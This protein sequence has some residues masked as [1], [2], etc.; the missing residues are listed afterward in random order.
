MDEGKVLAPV[1]P[2]LVQTDPKRT[3]ETME[4][5]LPPKYKLPKSS[6]GNGYQR[7]RPENCYAKDVS[8]RLQQEH[9]KKV[10]NAPSISLSFPVCPPYFPICPML[11][12]VI[13][14]EKRYSLPDIPKT[15]LP[16][17][18]SIIKIL[19]VFESVINLKP[20]LSTV[21]R[22]AHT[23]NL[24]SERLDLIRKDLSALPQALEK[25]FPE[26]SKECKELVAAVKVAELQYVMDGQS[27]V[28]LLPNDLEYGNWATFLRWREQQINLANVSEQSLPVR[29]E[30]CRITRH[31]PAEA[32]KAMREIHSK[33]FP[34]LK[35]L[36]DRAREYN[37]LQNEI[38][39]IVAENL[40]GQI[41]TKPLN[42]EEQKKPTMVEYLSGLLNLLEELQ[43]A[44]KNKNEKI[45]RIIHSH[46]GR[47]EK[48]IGSME[49]LAD[50]LRW[51]QSKYGC[52]NE[53]THS[54]LDW[55]SA[56]IP[57]KG[58]YPYPALWDA[59]ADPRFINELKRWIKSA[60]SR[61]EETKPIELNSKRPVTLDTFMMEYCDSKNCDIPSKRLAIYKAAKQKRITLPKLAKKW[62]T[63]KTKVFYDTDLEA[64]WFNYCKEITTLPTL[65]S[66]KAYPSVEKRRKA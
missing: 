57:S 45:I 51:C 10:Y 5:R 49:H 13:K 24:L 22:C 1:L 63:G 34:L 23:E 42:G 60:S 37:H 66:K 32:I 50:V 20:D 47:I 59:L 6:N 58:L 16:L 53:Y 39:K 25:D 40:V 28:Y 65:K 43:A 7:Y 27:F 17:L 48:Y 64:I 62:K 61:T 29:M 44:I 55:V 21:V 46:N 26:T 3:G 14:Q 52:H 19:I 12:K 31:Y 4:I 56:V 9:Q 38:R 41:G 54:A 2:A 15:N 8:I 33:L 18:D 36:P 11:K 30:M 35:I